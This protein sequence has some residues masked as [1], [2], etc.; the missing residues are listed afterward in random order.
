MH[1]VISNRKPSYCGL[2]KS[3]FFSHYRKSQ[4][5]GPWVSSVAQYSVQN[6]SVLRC[7]RFSWPLLH[8]PGWLLQPWPSILLLRKKKKK[9][10]ERESAVSWIT[11]HFYWGTGALLSWGAFLLRLWSHPGYRS[12]VKAVAGLE[13]ASAGAHCPVMTCDLWWVQPLSPLRI[14]PRC[15][16]C[17]F[18]SEEKR[19]SDSNSFHVR[20][21][22]VCPNFHLGILREVAS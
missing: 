17:L 18:E 3:M 1:S 7:L 19:D 20:N 13:P 6:W 15:C 5:S 12:K 11:C 4:S 9:T 16:L 8:G 14:L 2:S 22:R 10:G 21:D